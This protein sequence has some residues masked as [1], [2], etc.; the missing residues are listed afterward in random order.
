MSKEELEKVLGNESVFK[1]KDKDIEAKKNMIDR[2]LR[3]NEAELKALRYKQD[4]FKL[5]TIMRLT[6]K[7]RDD[8]MDLIEARKR[9]EE[10][11]KWINSKHKDKSKSPIQLKKAVH[12]VTGR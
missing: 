4:K 1:N 9:A 5:E 3:A 8:G 10:R 6:M 2:N 11:F 12:N 7:Y